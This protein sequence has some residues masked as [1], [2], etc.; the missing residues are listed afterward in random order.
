MMAGV[1]PVIQPAP[2]TGAVGKKRPIARIGSCAE[3]P[4]FRVVGSGVLETAPDPIGRPGAPTQSRQDLATVFRSSS[5]AQEIGNHVV[6]FERSQAPHAI[7]DGQAGEG[8]RKKRVRAGSRSEVTHLRPAVADRR[9]N[10]PP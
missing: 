7:V 3:G 8:R 10:E 5:H 9:G 6:G 2:L 1:A 4:V